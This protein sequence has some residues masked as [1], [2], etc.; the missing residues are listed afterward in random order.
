ME[1]NAPGWPSACGLGFR[2]TPRELCSEAKALSQIRSKQQQSTMVGAR[3]MLGANHHEQR[4]V[5]PCE[6]HQRG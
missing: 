4:D 5:D 3:T 6:L 1:L 2:E